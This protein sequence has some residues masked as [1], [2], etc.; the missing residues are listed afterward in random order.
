MLSNTCHMLS[1]NF[2]LFKDYNT[3]MCCV[4]N[5]ICCVILDNIWIATCFSDDWEGMWYFWDSGSPNLSHMQATYLRL[6]NLIPP[7]PNPTSCTLLYLPYRPYPVLSSPDDAHSQ[8]CSPFDE[9]TILLC[10][11]WHG[12]VGWQKPDWGVYSKKRRQVCIASTCLLW[13]F[14]RQ[15]CN[16]AFVPE[17]TRWLRK[18]SLYL[19][20]PVNRPLL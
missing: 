4:R 10:D 19:I 5:L 3:M 14:G 13:I 9:H 17:K 7:S 11:I 15:V 12:N 16:F 1:N 20:F 18:T 2:H 6:L 8:V